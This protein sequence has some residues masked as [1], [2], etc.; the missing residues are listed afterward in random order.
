[1][2]EVSESLRRFASKEHPDVNDLLLRVVKG[3]LL[4]SLEP[5]ELVRVSALVREKGDP[6][7]GRKLYLNN[8]AV[9]CITCPT[10]HR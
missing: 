8:K 7:R 10:E 2:S 9:A 4:V 3:G 6:I 1:M 5:K